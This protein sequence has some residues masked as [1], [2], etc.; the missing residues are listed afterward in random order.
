MANIKIIT[1]NNVGTRGYTAPISTDDHIRLQVC[2]KSTP[3]QKTVWT[4]IFQGTIQEISYEFGESNVTDL[5][6]VGYMD[7][8]VW[9][10]IE[11]TTSWTTL[12]DA[13]DLFGY[14]INNKGYRRWL[15]VSQ[16]YALTGVTFTSYNT[17]I[18][19]TYLSDVIS[20]MEKYSGYKYRATALPVY[21][22]NR[23]ITGLVLVWKPLST[24]VTDKYKV[25]EGTSRY[26]SSNFSSSIEDLKTQYTVNGSTSTG[27]F[28]TVPDGPQI[29]KYGKKAQVETYNW[30]NSI[31]QCK[32]IAESCVD[33]LKV[34]HLAGNAKIIGTPLA[35]VGDLVYCKSLS[36][37]IEGSAVDTNMTVYRVSHNISADGNYTTSL[38]LGRIYK[39]AYDY[40]GYIVKSASVSK[41]NCHKS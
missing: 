29:A 22:V 24:T 25:I 6:I 9:S 12:T 36:Q 4:D 13:R 27:V 26:I 5:K 15:S 38:D 7:E 23:H 19:Q 2:I 32:R 3:L 41:K 20:D 11:E 16:T 10:L 35:T 8:V 40:I 37:E 18:G 14:L 34:P 33:D 39:T 17:S 30:V 28:Y 31:T 21:D 1:N